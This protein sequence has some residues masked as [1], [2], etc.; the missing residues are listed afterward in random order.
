M[1]SDPKI[2]MIFGAG[3]SVTDIDFIANGK[4]LS[5]TETISPGDILIIDAQE[6]S[7]TLGGI[8]VDYT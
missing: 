5:I 2:Y 7:V 3:T 8:E 6:K 4:T 1:E